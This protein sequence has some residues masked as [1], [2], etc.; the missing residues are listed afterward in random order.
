MKATIVQPTI[1]FE[2][3]TGHRL[4]LEAENGHDR[5]LLRKLYENYHRTNSG[6]TSAGVI[7][8]VAVAIERIEA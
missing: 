6:F 5:K 8:H 3:Q 7:E 1:N 4:F 2:E